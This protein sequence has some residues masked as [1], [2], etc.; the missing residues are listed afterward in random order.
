[1]AEVSFSVSIYVRT[2]EESPRVLLVKHHKVGAYVP[3][4]GKVRDGEAP[5]EAA[6]RELAEEAGLDVVFPSKTTHRDGLFQ[7]PGFLAY[8]EHS[9]GEGRWHCNIAFVAEVADTDEVQLECPEW[10]SPLWVRE[11]PDG[12]PGNVKALV[13]LARS[14]YR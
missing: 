4:G 2:Q 5:F 3:I 13:K 7:P 11:A 8:E 12:S 1:M 6:W 10:D 14:R 9:A